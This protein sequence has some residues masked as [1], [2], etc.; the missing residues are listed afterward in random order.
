MIRRVVVVETVP[1]NSC[2]GGR[3]VGLK[4]ALNKLV[5]VMVVGTVADRSS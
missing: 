4:T 3:T 5:A 1:G 2:A